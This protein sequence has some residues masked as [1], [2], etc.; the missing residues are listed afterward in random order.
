[1]RSGVAAVVRGYGWGWALGFRL[2]CLLAS[3]FDALTS[4][5]VSALSSRG[6]DRKPRLSPD[7]GSGFVW[8]LEL[9]W[10]GTRGVS[11]ST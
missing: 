10:V 6:L 4:H 3:L 7:A 8:L 1:M 5:G 9:G 2:W 11:V